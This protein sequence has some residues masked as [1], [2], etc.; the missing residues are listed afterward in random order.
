M[1]IMEIRPSVYILADYGKGDLAFAEVHQQ[2]RNR[3]PTADVQEVPAVPLSTVHT[4]FLLYQL[5]LGHQQV[6]DELKGKGQTPKTY[7]Y[8][9]TAPRKDDLSARRDNE[10]EGLVY[11]KLKSGAEVVGVFSEYT[12]SFVKPLIQ[13]F[14]Q[15]NCTAGGSQFRSRDTF[16]QEFARIVH[17]DY[18]NLG[19]KI[20]AKSIKGP[21]FDNSILHIDGY[22]NIKLAKLP[23]EG[24]KSGDQLN[25]TMN[26]KTQSAIYTDGIFSVP[27]GF[28]S[29][30]PGS[31]GIKG[32]NL[33]EVVKRGGS[34]AEVFG[35][36]K[37]ETKVFIEVMR[38]PNS[39]ILV[40]V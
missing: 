2:I 34:A 15:I 1:V 21:I 22:G 17:G 27:H 37:V 6:Q 8:V 3:I 24:L 30:A 18:S 33:L 25:I 9:N 13:E 10:G 7:Y 20:D 4:G 16:P 26:G 5:A 19:A 31:S 28:L 11:A 39:R 12:F 14:R 40:R 32:Q 35:H 29:L 36:P 38:K 23:D